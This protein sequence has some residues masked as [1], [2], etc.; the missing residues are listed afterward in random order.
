MSTL[1]KLTNIFRVVAFV[2]TDVLV[3]TSGRLRAFDGNAI[4]GCLKK[5]DVVRVG[6]AYFNAQ[7]HTVAIGEHGSLGA[8]FPAISRVFTGFFPHPEATSSSLRPRFANST[9]CLGVRRIQGV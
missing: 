9:G 6:A 3:S 4:E 1:E 8:Q 7:W 5:F 2:E